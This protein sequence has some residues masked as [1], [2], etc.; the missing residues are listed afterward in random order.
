M[1][2][3]IEGGVRYPSIDQ[4]PEIARALNFDLAILSLIFLRDRSPKIYDALADHMIN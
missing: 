3:K 4:I 1:V 2:S